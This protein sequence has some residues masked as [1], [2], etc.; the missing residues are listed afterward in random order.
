MSPLSQNDMGRAF[1]YGVALS[2]S[3]ALPAKLQEDDRLR[4][5]M[6]CFERC[7]DREQENI[8]RASKEIAAFLSAHDNRLADTGC[9]VYLQSDQAGQ[10]GDVRDV[11][12]HNETLNDDIGISAKNRHWAVKHS[13]LSEQIDFGF[14]WFGIH[15]SDEYLHAVTLIFRELRTRQRRG[16]L[17]RNIPDKQQRYYVPIL[18]LFQTEMN[19]LF[20]SNPSSVARGL[21][22]YL[23]GKYDYYKVIKENG[24]V[25]IKSFN[26]DG[27]LRWGSRMPLPTRIIE[28]SPKPNTK[29]TLIMIFDKGWQ[30]SFR[31]HNASTRVE[32]SLKFDINIVGLPERVA[33]QSIRY[34]G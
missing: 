26:I 9:S 27:T 4:T 10:Q 2:L 5:T 7:S 19:R 13:R 17:W 32:P 3:Q 20:Q 15:C 29:T 12:V 11:I 34:R 1:E 8:V 30:L 14:D 6:H 18:E 31:I 21:L 22:K 28:I 16:E 24:N 33:S 25:A 23:L